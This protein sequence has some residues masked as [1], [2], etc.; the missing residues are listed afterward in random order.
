METAEIQLLSV[1]H[2]L[3][4]FFFSF[5]KHTLCTNENVVAAKY[6]PLKHGWHYYT[7]PVKSLDTLTQVAWYCIFSTLEHTTLAPLPC[8]HLSTPTSIIF[9]QKWESLKYFF[10]IFFSPFP[11]L[12]KQE[13]HMNSALK[14]FST[15]GSSSYSVYVQIVSLTNVFLVAFF[16]FFI[17]HNIGTLTQTNKMFHS[18][19]L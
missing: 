12:L 19:L 16:F 11:V 1:S 15:T 2:Y 18:C 3:I 14:V 7:V 9:Y 4:F 10:L 17:I 6:F 8:L 5:S 13:L